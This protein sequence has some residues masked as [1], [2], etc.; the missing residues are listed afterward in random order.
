ML[1]MRKV[2]AQLA[3]GAP[4]MDAARDL[5]LATND[6]GMLA[7]LAV[8]FGQFHR[9]E[10]PRGLLSAALGTLFGCGALYSIASHAAI[11]QT[12]ILDS[13]T[14]FVG[15]AG[16]FLGAPGLAITLLV[17]AIA[18]LLLDPAMG[19]IFDLA[20]AAALGRA[21]SVATAGRDRASPIS[22]LLLGGLLTIAVLAKAIL[23]GGLDQIAQTA[24][25]SVVLTLLASTIL[26]SFIERERQLISNERQL[27]SQAHTDPLTGLSNRRALEDDVSR[28]SARGAFAARALLV[29]DVDHF[30]A[31]N[32][33]YGHHAGDA[34]LQ[35]LADTLRNTVRLGDSVY[36]MGGEEFAVLLAAGSMDEAEQGAHRLRRAVE[37]IRL[38]VGGKEIGC[39]VSVGLSWF[40][41]A[42]AFQDSLEAAD[43][44]LYR[45]KNA[46][47]NAVVSANWPLRDGGHVTTIAGK[48][49]SFAILAANGDGT[50]VGRGETNTPSRPFR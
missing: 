15:F 23:H 31:V 36:R 34:L 8:A 2:A 38:R 19:S 22:L 32:D 45:A 6:L 20:L 48:D 21:W 49:S 39:T 17:G 10:L 24:P 14:V 46:G 33:A 16:A 26:G 9:M 3:L 7:F 12:T 25:Q 35:K 1:G 13:G 44:A 47:R 18:R 27:R 4:A 30:K 11:G 40:N 41:S 50:K 5:L 29:I 43:R 37:Q 42:V 28:Q